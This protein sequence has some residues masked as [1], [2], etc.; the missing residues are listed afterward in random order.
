M[1]LTAV[2]APQPGR[3]RGNK[4]SDETEKEGCADLLV[5]LAAAPVGA[6]LRGWAMVH[7][8]G[9]FVTPVFSVPAPTLAM[10][11]GLSFTAQVFIV[12]PRGGK[13]K[14]SLLSQALKA[15]LLPLVI[16][17]CG[18]CVHWLVVQGY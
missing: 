18:W 16:A 7:L 15:V 8:W 2:A 13:K 14:Q 4:M 17:G 3:P 11:I 10:C 1:K 5:F 6:V 12:A 9:W